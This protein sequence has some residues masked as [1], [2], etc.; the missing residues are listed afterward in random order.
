MPD[1]DADRAIRDDGEF[2][3]VLNSNC[4]PEKANA[5]LQR[6]CAAGPQAPGGWE[7]VGSADMDTVS[8]KWIAD[9]AAPY[10]EDTGSDVL[11]LGTF[12][13]QQDAINALWEG[14]HQALCRQPRY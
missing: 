1:N 8:G 12:D 2:Y 11:A 7:C 5:F 9:V 6:R 4:P 3:V 13:N 10:D 14:R